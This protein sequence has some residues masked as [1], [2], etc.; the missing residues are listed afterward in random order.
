M[1]NKAISDVCAV[2]DM[3]SFM[4]QIA[5]ENKRCLRGQSVF[6]SVPVIL[7]YEGTVNVLL[8]S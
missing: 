4:E 7:D 2:K 8:E 3:L 6:F 1:E 5:V